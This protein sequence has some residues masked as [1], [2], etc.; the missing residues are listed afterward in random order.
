MAAVDT[1]LV[2]EVRNFLFS[3]HGMPGGDLA[4]RNIQRGRDHYLPSFNDAV[5]ALGLG[6]APANFSELAGDASVAA[7]L[8]AAY[9]DG[10]VENVDLWVGGLAEGMHGE[11][12]S[13]GKSHVGP[14]FAAL[15]VEQFERTRAA[16]RFWFEGSSWS[17]AERAELKSAGGMAGLLARTSTVKTSF[18]FALVSDVSAAGACAAGG[19]A[20]PTSGEIVVTSDPK[21]SIRWAY[22]STGGGGA[23]NDNGRPRAGASGASIVFTL[24]LPVGTYLGL[25]WGSTEDGMT[26]SDMLIAVAHPDG[27]TVRVEDCWS[28]TYEPPK[29][30]VDLFTPSG[31]KHNMTLAYKN[32]L[33]LLNY[34]VAADT[35]VAT[36]S[37]RRLVDTGDTASDSPIRAGQILV[38]I[39]F[40]GLD[41][42]TPLPMWTYH[43]PSGRR[44][45]N[46]AFFG[47][48]ADGKSPKRV[49]PDGLDSRRSLQLIHGV[50]MCIIWGINITIGVF[51]ARYT[52]HRTWW[53]GAHRLLQS[54]S[55]IITWPT[56][57]IATQM[58][59]VHFNSVH[60]YIGIFITVVTSAQAFLGTFAVTVKRLQARR[61][62][63]SVSVKTLSRSASTHVERLEEKLAL[64]EN[65]HKLS[66]KSRIVHR[67]VGR[68]LVALAVLQVR[69]SVCVGGGGVGS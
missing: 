5:R 37:V 19:L 53:F 34:T 40:G 59:R 69:V 18:P 9:G 33:E 21:R 29:R 39:A 57:Y 56:L 1:S 50:M 38:N 43:T 68:C 60:A 35:G 42:N 47:G 24:T 44:I 58:V 41:S 46:V 15:I 7:A 67:I 12:S 3:V 8:R 63:A 54:M 2:D 36:L 10:G 45:M 51:V 13:G 11:E 14:V 49:L 26:A 16:D 22:D 30:D 23:T 28:E 4:A 61:L 32:D 55:T 27:K 62:T 48:G 17:D 6:P 20:A 65:K 25:G 64:V 66:A 31:G 52:R